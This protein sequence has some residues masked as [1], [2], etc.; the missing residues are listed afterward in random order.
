MIALY[1]S[2]CGTGKPVPYGCYYPCMHSLSTLTVRYGLAHTTQLTLIV[3]LHFVLVL[4]YR[5]ACTLLRVLLPLYA[6]SQYFNCKVWACP[7]HATNFD[8]ATTLCSPVQASLYLT[9]V[10][11]FC[12]TGKPV[13]YRLWQLVANSAFRTPHLIILPYFNLYKYKLK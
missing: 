13:P 11:F 8:S 4:R 3:Q 2:F 12:G 5:Q 6:L 1:Y 9:G 7:Y 10:L